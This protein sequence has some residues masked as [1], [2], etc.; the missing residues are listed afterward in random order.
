M[1]DGC[2]IPHFLVAGLLSAAFHAGVAPV[3]AGASQNPPVSTSDFVGVTEVPSNERFPMGEGRAALK[4]ASENETVA[5]PEDCVTIPIDGSGAGATVVCDWGWLALEGGLCLAS[6]GI[7]GIKF[8]KI[9]RKIR[10]AIKKGNAGFID[11]MAG[12]VTGVF[13]GSMWSEIRECVS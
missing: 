10:K 2:R 5:L 13:C 8:F 12:V 11:Y 4:L 1:K 9:A 3:A 6:V 7:V